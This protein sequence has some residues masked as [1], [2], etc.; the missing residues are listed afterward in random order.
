MDPRNLSKYSLR[1]FSKL[2]FIESTTDFFK[3]ND[4]KMQ[5]ETNKNSINNVN[6]IGGKLRNN[7]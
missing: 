1:A 6:G 5:E 2:Q 3:R 4:V 7:M